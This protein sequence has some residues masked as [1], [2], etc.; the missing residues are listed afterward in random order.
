[1]TRR[2]LPTVLVVAVVAAVAWTLMGP[3]GPATRT[4]D[5]IAVEIAEQKTEMNA[6]IA[7]G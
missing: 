3:T 6:L 1:M 4:A 5:Q 2:I 7:A